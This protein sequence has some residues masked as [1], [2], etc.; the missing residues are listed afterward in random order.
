MCLI[1]PKEQREVVTT[2]DKVVY[3]ILVVEDRELRSPYYRYPYTLGKKETAEMVRG[4]NTAPMCFIDLKLAEEYCADRD[5]AVVFRGI[6]RGIH[7]VVDVD[8][9]RSLLEHKFD[10]RVYVECLIPAGSEIIEAWGL[11]VT[12]CL[13]PLKIID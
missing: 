8:M 10:R 9:Y 11:G 13:I 6:S 5:W 12:N 1:I 3:K 2:E 4:D 7:Y